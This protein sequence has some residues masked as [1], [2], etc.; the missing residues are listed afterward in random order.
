MA[1]RK[2]HTPDDS[3]I[4]MLL[5]LL[6][7][8]GR[9]GAR[10]RLALCM[11]SLFSYWILLVLLMDSPS[12]G[13]AINAKVGFVLSLVAQLGRVFFSSRVLRHLLPVIAGCWLAFRIASHYMDSQYDIGSH[14]ISA[15]TLRLA[16]FGGRYETLEI[17]DGD[18]AKIP[19]HHPLLRIGGPGFLNMR[20]GFVGL[21]ETIDGTIQIHGPGQIFIRGGERLI[22]VI[23]LRDQSRSIHRLRALTRDGIEIRADD[24]QMV[25]HVYSGDQPRGRKNPFPCEP[26]AIWRLFHHQPVTS[27]GHQT[28]DRNLEDLIQ[29]E[30]SRFVLEH[31]LQ[32]LLAMSADPQTGTVQP[33]AEAQRSTSFHIPQRL[34]TQRFLSPAVQRR[35]RKAGITLQWIRIGKW[36]I[37]HPS[38]DSQSVTSLLP[39][40]QDMLRAGMHSSAFALE[41]IRQEYRSAHMKQILSRWVELGQQ[42][43]DKDDMKRIDLLEDIVPMLEQINRDAAADPGYKPPAGMDQVLGLLREHIQGQTSTGAEET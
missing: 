28:W 3:L 1:E 7:G 20:L 30:I 21:V 12:A 8:R 13:K 18:W 29:S 38:A 17:R 15:H 35:L 41:G 31:T 11:L 37:S 36:E 6:L 40:R 27:P 24:V 39:I 25:Y 23:D 22:D 32:D 42:L 26:D 5:S 43:L 10:L 2:A 9:Q 4:A 16:M 14:A 33:D 34:L 19:S